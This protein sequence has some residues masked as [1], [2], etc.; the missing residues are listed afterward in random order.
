MFSG[1][2]KPVSRPTARPPAASERI[3][4]ASSLSLRMLV[5]GRAV[6]SMAC[7]WGVLS[8]SLHVLVFGRAVGT[9][10]CLWGIC[11]S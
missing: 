8:L 10:A 2:G 9:M 4:R 3:C 6:D 1:F 11:I 5:F 7:L